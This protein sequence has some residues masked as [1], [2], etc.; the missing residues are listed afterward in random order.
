MDRESDWDEGVPLVLF[1]VRETVQESLGFSPADLVF[2]HTVRGPL[3]VQKDAIIETKM[4]TKQNV[5][6]FVSQM[7]ERLYDACS[8]ARENLTRTQSSM[9]KQYDFKTVSRCFQVGDEV[10]VFLPVPGSALAARFSGLYKVVKRISE[11]DYIIDTPDR[12]RQTRVCH[13]NM[14]KAFNLR[15]NLP[16]AVEQKD[17]PV[18]TTAICERVSPSCRDTDVDQ[19]G[20]ILRNAVQQGARMSNYMMLQNLPQHLVYLSSSQKQDIMQLVKTFP[21]LFYD[22][23]TQTTVLKHDIKVSNSAP[24]KQHAYRVNMMKQSV[25]RA[26]VDY[27]VE[28][29]LAVPSCSPWSSPCLLVPK[30]DGTYR[31]CTDY[32]KVN[33]VTVSDSYPLPRME[34]CIDNLGS[35]QFVSKLDLLKGYWQVPLTPRACEISAF[36]TPDNFLQYSVM[37]FGMQNAAATFQRLVNIVLAGV[38]NRN[39]YLD[40]LVVY[41]FDWAEHLALL[42][43]L[44][45]LGSCILNS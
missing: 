45:T 1:A 28:N 25:M 30:P 13:V 15:K 22:V 6:D 32:R 37:A 41:S 18:V 21:Q 10:L 44:Q 23:P 35:A 38:P 20:V 26:E 4:T 27:L 42:T 2:G 11:T 33:S 36:I 14:L 3:K 24:I 29:G 31:F 5:L 19:D 43:C 9:K 8:L 7:R 34:D 12:N 16:G 17:A 39:A 40:D